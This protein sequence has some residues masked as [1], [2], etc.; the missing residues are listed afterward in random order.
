MG[1]ILVVNDDGAV[2]EVL[3]EALVE[4]MHLEVAAA[5]SGAEALEVLRSLRPAMILLDIGRT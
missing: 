3:A 5:T 4:E 2:R 1:P